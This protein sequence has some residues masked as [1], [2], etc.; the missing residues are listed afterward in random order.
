M[1]TWFLRTW[2]KCARQDRCAMKNGFPVPAYVSV[3]VFICAHGNPK[4]CHKCQ[5]GLCCDSYTPLSCCLHCNPAEQH[6]NYELD[7]ARNV[8]PFSPWHKHAFF[9]GFKQ[10][11]SEKKTQL[12]LIKSMSPNPRLR[13]RRWRMIWGCWMPH[14]QNWCEKHI[15][16][17]LQEH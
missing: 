16:T 3:C 2:A 7:Y 10:C 9:W 12:P 17:C 13:R 14:F 15:R 11:W 4:P 6:S 8:S 5:L 1:L